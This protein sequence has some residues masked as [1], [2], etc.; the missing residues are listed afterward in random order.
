M[1][2]NTKKKRDKAYWEYLDWYLAHAFAFPSMR[3]DKNHQ[4]IVLPDT[5]IKMLES[6]SKGRFGGKP[7]AFLDLTLDVQFQLLKWIHVF[8]YPLKS[9]NDK[10]SSYVLK[11]RAERYMCIDETYISNDEMKGAMLLGG[12]EPKDPN[13]LNWVFKAGWLLPS[14][15]DETLERLANEFAERGGM[16]CNKHLK[17]K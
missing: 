1:V 7:V 9:Y 2:M 4:M 17:R 13:E 14:W 6:Y 15:T 3:D 10:Y 5:A 11:H 12:Y 8:A 16:L